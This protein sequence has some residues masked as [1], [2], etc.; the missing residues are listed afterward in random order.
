MS[1]WIHQ[2]FESGTQIVRRDDSEGP[3]LYVYGPAGEDEGST[4]RNRYHTCDQLMNFLNGGPRPAWLDDLDRVNE[5]ALEGP[6]GTRIDATGPMVDRDPPNLQ[7]WNDESDEA[8]DAR[9][10]LID[11]LAGVDATGG[12]K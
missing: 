8:K 10:R 6:D 11:R 4:D 5:T 1:K 7:W 3:W 9:A 2:L 12:V